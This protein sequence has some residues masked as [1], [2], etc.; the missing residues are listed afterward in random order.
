MT[1]KNWL[2]AAVEAGLWYAFIYYFLYA[3]KNPVDLVQSAIVLVIIMYTASMMC[4]LLRET[5]AWKRLWK[6]K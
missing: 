2:S 6:Q 3:I 5:D 1:T 4:P